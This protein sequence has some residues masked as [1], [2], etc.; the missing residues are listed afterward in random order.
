[1]AADDTKKQKVCCTFDLQCTVNQRVELIVDSHMHIESNNTAPLPLVWDK[2]KLFT[3]LKPSKSTI[4]AAG[5]L[6]FASKLAKEAEIGRDAT[7]IIADK[8][9]KQ[10]DQTFHPEENKLVIN[11]VM[12]MDMEYGHF[13]GYFGNKIYRIE[14]R[15]KTKWRYYGTVV[16]PESKK[17]DFMLYNARKSDS[18]EGRKE[19]EMPENE[20]KLFEHFQMQMER[21][22]YSAIKHPFRLMPLYHFDPRRWNTKA[23][24]QL[25]NAKGEL[26]IKSV[27]TK[28]AAPWEEQEGLLSPFSETIFGDD[29]GVLGEKTDHKGMFIGFKIYT[30]LGYMPDDP[31]LPVLQKLYEYCEKKDFPIMCHGTKRGM[32]T[33]DKPLFAELLEANYGKREFVKPQNGGYGQGYAD[34]GKAIQ[35]NDSNDKIAKQNLANSLSWYNKHYISPRDAWG[36]VLKKYSKLRICLA[37]FTGDKSKEYDDNDGWDNWVKWIDDNEDKD[38]GEWFETEC[39]D[40]WIIQMCEL[41]QNNT[42]VYTDL[43][44]VLLKDKKKP[45]A[46]VLKK[47]PKLKD[48]IL[49]GTDW[50]LVEIDIGYSQFIS[51][52]REVLDSFGEGLWERFTCHNALRFYRL[53]E[54]A[55]DFHAALKSEAGLVA[56]KIDSGDLSGDADLDDVEVQPQQEELSEEDEKWQDGL[57]WLEKNKS[58]LDLLAEKR[59][60]LLMNTRSPTWES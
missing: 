34:L 50:H 18:D 24:N 59:K 32:Y 5:L 43:S 26:G 16:I 21:T 42:N 7:Q 53:K 56:K 58:V 60:K 54:I 41:V 28:T 23:N 19:Y 52:N 47:Y 22:K 29:E 30:A 12:P 17:N 13:D 3:I 8:I 27:Q 48:R 36:P 55:N 2:S 40:S 9:I 46:W 35:A 10:N 1:M 14:T 57:Q 39:K 37:H 15:K 49:F 51:Q 20:L 11:M 33:L 25:I 6:S 4:N 44:Y 45:L 38:P 31:N